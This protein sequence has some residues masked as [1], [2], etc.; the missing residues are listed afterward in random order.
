MIFRRSFLICAAAAVCGMLMQARAA[1]ASETCHLF[2]EISVDAVQ[3]HA[4]KVCL[5]TKNR[6][7]CA[8]AIAAQNAALKQLATNATED[9]CKFVVKQLGPVVTIDVT[10]K[11]ED[12]E[13]FNEATKVLKKCA[14]LVVLEESR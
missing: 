9:G 13:K 5:K 7:A 2:A 3:L 12:A 6:V 14:D 4:M 11:K 8:I 1:T 10:S